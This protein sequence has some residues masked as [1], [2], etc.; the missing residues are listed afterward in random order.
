MQFIAEPALI[1]EC[2]GELLEAYYANRYPYIEGVMDFPQQSRNLPQNLVR[3]GIEEANYFFALCN[4]M[5]GATDSMMMAHRFRTL[6][7]YTSETLFNWTVVS[8][9]DRD[10]L[11]A[12]LREAGLDFRANEVPD[13]WIENAQRILE[14]YDGDIRALYPRAN[15]DW[16]TLQTLLVNTDQGEGFRGFKAKMARMLTFYMMRQELVDYFLV[17]PQVDFHVMRI[18]WACRLVIPHDDTDTE[19]QRLNSG[20][21]V[22]YAHGV[23]EALYEHLSKSGQNWLDMSDALWTFSRSMC[24]QAPCNTASKGI[25]GTKERPAVLPRPT[26]VTWS[27]VQR[28]AYRRSCG[29]CPIEHLCKS[30]VPS[31]FYYGFDN[32]TLGT[33]PREREPQDQL[34]L[35]LP[36]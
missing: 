5:L 17:P 36:D 16:R 35:I 9:M 30:G 33:V 21:I 28:L 23:T 27:H 7:E 15:Q 26:P 34:T 32:T 2:L 12:R 10:A 25:K 3:G 11:R 13:I 31:A 20:Q 14:R 24:S 22:K 18:F 1:E 6:Y 8:S 19:M 29:R 4:Y